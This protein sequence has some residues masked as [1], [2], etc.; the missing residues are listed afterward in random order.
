L[1]KISCKWEIEVRKMQL[2]LEANVEYNGT[3]R[4]LMYRKGNV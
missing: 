1:F 4:E 2:L 3:L